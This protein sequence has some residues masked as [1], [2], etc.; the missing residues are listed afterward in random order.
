[1]IALKYFNGTLDSSDFVAAAIVLAVF[2]VPIVFD[3]A[4]GGG[5]L[6]FGAFCAL[7]LGLQG[8]GYFILFSGLIQS[9]LLL[10][11]RRKSFAFAPAMSAAALVAYMI[12]DT[13]VG[14]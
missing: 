7:F 8:I 9:V 10:L 4:F 11:L 13:G 3:M 12:I 1:M 14:N 2:V 5:D 6:R